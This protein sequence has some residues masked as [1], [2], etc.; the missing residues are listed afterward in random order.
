[1][2]AAMRHRAGEGWIEVSE[3]GRI[4]AVEAAGKRDSFVFSSIKI[5]DQH[6][7]T[8]VKTES[9]NSRLCLSCPQENAESFGFV[10]RHGIDSRFHISER[11][12]IVRLLDSRMPRGECYS[13][14]AGFSLTVIESKGVAV[15]IWSDEQTEF[16]RMNRAERR[17]ERHHESFTFSITVPSTYR[18]LVSVHDTLE[19]AVEAYISWIS[20]DLGFQPRSKRKGS[21]GWVEDV[22][23][24]FT[25]DMLRSN[26]EISHNYDDLMRLA[27]ELAA[28]DCPK[29]TVFYLPGWNGPYDAAYP[30]Y[31]P[32]EEL[33]GESSFASMMETIHG[34]GFRVMV[35]TNPGGLDPYHPDIDSLL[36]YALKDSEGRYAGFQTPS[37]RFPDEYLYRS[38]EPERIDQAKLGQWVPGFRKLAFAADGLSVEGNLLTVN[39][40]P[41]F[42]EAMVTVSA[43]PSGSGGLRISLD[44]RS[45]A[46]PLGWF[47]EQKDFTFPFALRLHPGRNRISV[48][49]LD[50]GS[51]ARFRVHDCR[52]PPDPASTWTYPILAGDN[53]NDEWNQLVV[54][55]IAETVEKFSIDAIHCDATEYQW[56]LHY[57]EVLA[58]RLPQT[59][60]GGE[61]YSTLSALGYF[62]FAQ[63]HDNMSL[64]RYPST[65]RGTLFQGSLPDWSDLDAALAWLNMASPASGYANMFCRVY[66]HLCAAD[67]FVP[68]GKV[69]T[70]SEAIKS[71]RETSHLKSVL[72]DAVRLNYIPALRVNYREYGLDSD[73]AWFVKS[74]SKE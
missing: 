21:P 43:V 48:E 50:E 62:D 60:I 26:G 51:S 63:S 36:K 45:V 72:A 22:R 1:M 14:N 67:A 74:L 32:R 64:I 57:Y 61:G 34:H 49:G 24:F 38:L 44:E 15:A 16:Q 71:P 5:D 2:E 37:A 8:G 3:G 70:C 7:A 13:V 27:D 28:I 54:G 29:D 17:V 39:D 20:D 11:Y 12:N 10:L 6:V 9:D 42:C 47:N 59:A 19:G 40:V 65:Y 55:N 73:T 31:R 52:V 58:R 53:E 33:G 56:N 23:L 41:D 25:V 69:C 30:N 66:P 4:A 68:V 35:H 46:S 18:I